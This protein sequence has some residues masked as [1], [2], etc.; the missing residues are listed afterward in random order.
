MSAFE[1]DAFI[2]DA[3]EEIGRVP[4]T[5]LGVEVLANVV[6]ACDR[7]TPGTRM[8]A[9]NDRYFIVSPAGRFGKKECELSGS[10]GFRQHEV[11]KGLELIV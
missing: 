8:T 4:F 2:A 10:Y 1:T 11:S 5:R 7:S 6:G 9:A 3:E